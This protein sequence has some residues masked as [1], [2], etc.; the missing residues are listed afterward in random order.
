MA[1]IRLVTRADDA[2]LNHSTNRA[3]RASVKQGIAHN[4]SLLATTPSIEDASKVLADLHGIVNFGLHVCLTSEWRNP[5]FKPLGSKVQSMVRDD[6]SFPA[7]LDELATHAP[8]DDEIISEVTAQYEKLISLG[9]QLSYL[10]EHMSIGGIAGIADVLTDFAKENELVYDR[11]LRNAQVISPLVGWQG[12]GP[13]PGT[14]LADHLSSTPAG[15]Y[16]V[17]G[18]PGFKSDEMQ[19]LRRDAGDEY[20]ALQERN[21]QRR[22]FADIEIVDYCDNA[23]VKLLRYTDL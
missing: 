8:K 3:I 15:T 9:F 1:T 23:P 5:R 7:S 20:D 21:R 22:M 13:H 16:L 14:E 2:G 10:D 19:Q 17:V 6:G 4:I 12:P 11:T 18:H